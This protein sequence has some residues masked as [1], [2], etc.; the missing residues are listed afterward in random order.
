MRAPPF[1]CK[2]VW[3]SGHL[4][5]YKQLI[6]TNSTSNFL[7][8]LQSRNAQRKK[9][10]ALPNHNFIAL[11]S[12]DK[13]VPP[14]TVH[15]VG[16]KVFIETEAESIMLSVEQAKTLSYFIADRLVRVADFTDDL[17]GR[18]DDY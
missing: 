17:G 2:I 15:I 12:S 13:F 16:D 10:S 6:K 1:L 4:K 11:K 14:A 9:S 3:A 18:G 5:S 7:R 8:L